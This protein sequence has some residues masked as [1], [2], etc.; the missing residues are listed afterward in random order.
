MCSIITS[1]IVVSV[2]PKWMTKRIL[3]QDLLGLCFLH[4]HDI[5]D[6][7]IHPE[8][9]LFEVPDLD[10][11]T[12][13]ELEHDK[14][15]EAQLVTRPDGTSNEWGLPQY[16]TLAWPLIEHSCNRPDF[17]VKITDLGRGKFTWRTLISIHD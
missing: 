5:T 4:S 15:R 17:N 10:S 6:G 13:E 7:D 11:Y 8:Q 3:R 1:N 14:S 2:F 12:V 9:H 16:I